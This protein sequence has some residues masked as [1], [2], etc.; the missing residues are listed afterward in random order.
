MTLPKHAIQLTEDETHVTEA[1]TP[2]GDE[3]AHFAA[4]STSRF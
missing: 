4:Q 2:V 1:S 3:R